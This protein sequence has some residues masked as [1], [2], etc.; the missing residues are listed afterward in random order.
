MKMLMVLQ[1]IS[2]FL[3]DQKFE[4]LIIGNIKAVPDPI[5]ILTEI[6]S[7]KFVEKK[8]VNTNTYNKSNINNFSSNYFP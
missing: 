7:A 6:K 1:T 8:D 2:F 3:I 5:A 4:H